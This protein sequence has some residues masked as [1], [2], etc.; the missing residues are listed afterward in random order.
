MNIDLVNAG[1][2]RF[3][4]GFVAGGVASVVLIVGAGFQFHNLADLKTWLT[5]LAFAFVT[6]GLLAVEKMYNFTPSVQ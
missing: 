6:G 4:K 3:L 1:I 2:R 5:S